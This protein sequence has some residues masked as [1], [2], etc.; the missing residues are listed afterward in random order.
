[1]R[2]LALCLIFAFIGCGR[3]E[4]P[5]QSKPTP[6]PEKPFPLPEERPFPMPEPE[7]SSG[8]P[9][10]KVEGGK[11]TGE[12]GR[13]VQLRGMSLFWSQWSAPFWSASAVKETKLWG[14]TVIRAAMG[15]E[16]GGYLT[17]PSEAEKVYK[18]VEAAVENDIYVIIDWHAHDEHREEAIKF[19]SEMAQRYKDTPNVIFEIWNEPIGKSWEQV[20]GYSQAVV[21]AIRAWGAP[22]LVIVGTPNWS[23]DVD[24]AAAKPLADSNVAYSLH[25][26]AG[27]HRGELRAKAQTAID[28]GA[29]LFVTEWGTVNAWAQGKV[30]RGESDRWLAFL[31]QHQIGWTNWSLFDKPEAS[32]ALRQGVSPEGPW[33]EADLTESGRYVVEKLKS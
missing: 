3:Y 7:P 25:F 30:D 24:L 28:L 19:F 12:G 17:N 15:V 18:I 1:M 8:L 27:T 16:M 20:R 33:R 4:P 29:A 10:L 6:P 14:A 31:N 32:S 11:I 2:A 23:Q 21:G 22:N 13:P 5:K 26:Y 9:W